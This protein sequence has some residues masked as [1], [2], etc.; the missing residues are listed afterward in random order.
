MDVICRVGLTHDEGD[1][2]N[3]AKSD[4]S[5]RLSLVTCWRGIGTLREVDSLENV[6][7]SGHEFLKIGCNRGQE[8]REPPIRSTLLAQR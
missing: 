6:K 2:G 1:D 4:G 5:H 7:S 3:I 8:P